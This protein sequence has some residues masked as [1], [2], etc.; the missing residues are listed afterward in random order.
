MALQ[1]QEQ[2]WFDHSTPW[3][4]VTP[5]DFSELFKKSRIGREE[6]ARLAE[7]YEPEAQ[8]FDVS[9]LCLSDL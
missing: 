7:P 9:S 1:D 5:L 3:K 4:A 8:A 2:Y 6:H